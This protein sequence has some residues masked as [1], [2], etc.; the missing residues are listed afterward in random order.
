[1]TWY[2]SDICPQ[3]GKPH[4]LFFENKT[5]PKTSM[6][7]KFKCLDDLNNIKE[8]SLKDRPLRWR[9]EKLNTDAVFLRCYLTT[10]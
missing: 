8:V 7:I 9:K 6:N 10:N 4:P 3:C 1:M 5:E 2:S